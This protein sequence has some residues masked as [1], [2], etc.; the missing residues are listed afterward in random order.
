[1]DKQKTMSINLLLQ[2][3]LSVL[4]PIQYN[5]D[6]RE[7]E[8]WQQFFRGSCR[9][10]RVEQKNTICGNKVESSGD[11]TSAFYF[12]FKPSKQFLMLE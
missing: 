8:N 10:I 1:M 12:T 9:Y 2:P 6:D 11:L 7:S 5:R 3:P 4:A